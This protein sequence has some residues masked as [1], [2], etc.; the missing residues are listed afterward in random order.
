[1]PPSEFGGPPGGYAPPGPA[2]PPQGYPPGAGYAPPG[3]YPPAA[4]YAPDPSTYPP[5]APA[6]SGNGCL[7]AFLI[8]L[9]VLVVLSLA[10]VAAAI[11]GANRLW[12]N[13][14]GTADPADYSLSGDDMTCTISSSGLMTAAGTIT[15]KTDHPQ[16]FRISIDFV[17]GTDG[18]TL[19]SGSGVSGSIPAG[20]SATFDATDSVS[21]QPQALTCKVTDVSYFGS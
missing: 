15:N 17:E 3:A 10:G 6:K 21:R 13:T 2:G 16:A 5:A 11:Y 20:R 14:V 9:L 8:T 18:P 1:M 12:Q 4:G 19:G 7:K